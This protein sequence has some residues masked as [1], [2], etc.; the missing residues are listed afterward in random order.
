[1]LRYLIFDSNSCFFTLSGIRKPARRTSPDQAGLSLGNSCCGAYSKS[2]GFQVTRL[3]WDYTGSA[4]RRVLW[5]S[6]A[7]VVSISSRRDYRLSFFIVASPSPS[8]PSS[9]PS[10]ATHLV[11]HWATAHSASSPKTEMKTNKKPA[12]QNFSRIGSCHASLTWSSCFSGTGRPEMRDLTVAAL[13]MVPS[14][15]PSARRCS[16][17]AIMRPLRSASSCREFQ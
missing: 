5:S 14:P 10:V 4:F 8:F 3:S 2:Y 6:F 13:S 1:M 15:V 17:H 12:Q 11:V 16:S 9:H 7:R